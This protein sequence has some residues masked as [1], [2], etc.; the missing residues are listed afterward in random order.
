MKDGGVPKSCGV[1]IWERDIDMVPVHSHS[2]TLSYGLES[3][4]QNAEI[5]KPVET[6]RRLDLAT[7]GRGW[8]TSMGRKRLHV[9]VE[10]GSQLVL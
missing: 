1:R 3:R 7:S 9:C 5:R 6:F 10:K 2:S 4:C 8:G